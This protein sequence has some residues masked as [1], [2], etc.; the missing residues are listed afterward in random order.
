MR[1]DFLFVPLH[2]QT[3]NGLLLHQKAAA[4][5]EL[6]DTRDLKS[7]DPKRSCGFE[8]RS[9]HT[10]N[11]KNQKGRKR[12]T[13]SMVMR[14]LHSKIRWSQASFLILISFFTLMFSVISSCSSS[15]DEVSI[16]G[17]LLH[18]NQAT[19]YVYSPDGII[20][21]IDTIQ[22]QGGRFEYDRHVSGDGTLVIVL[23]NYSQMPIFVSPGAS[24]DIKGDAANM[25]QVKV[26]G[27]K[28][29]ESFNEWR[30]NNENNSP[31]EQK[32][33]AELY[34]QDHAGSPVS[35]WLLRQYYV[36]TEK[37]DRK[38]AIALLKGMLQE[39]PDYLPARRM[40]TEVS[41]IG[42]LQIGDK[43]GS[44][45]AKDVHGNVVTQNDLQQSTY[46]VMTC[47]TWNDDSKSM[48]T[49][50]IARRR[51]YEAGSEGATKSKVLVI[52][53]DANPAEYKRLAETYN[54]QD[55]IWV[56]DTLQWQSPLLKV[57]GLTAVPDN[58]VL[59]NGKVT[60]R[61][62]PADKL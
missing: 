55:I 40:L 4:M 50:I 21:G 22:V 39:E 19:F 58:V 43:I 33:H 9:R 25:K 12:K 14:M 3:L 61:R 49:S 17:R 51:G 48:L 36:L 42:N 5:V 46:I 35:L 20:E 2:P 37:P 15:S 29:N 1:I 30:E 24:I 60:R 57:F 6:V 47:A 26:K 34:I 52:S 7:L 56:H 41:E 31:I 13:C 16:E 59:T 54:Q 62:V 53:M 8:S 45:S 38:R 32:K 27:T 18:L 28:H 10:V 23:P 11:S 44:F